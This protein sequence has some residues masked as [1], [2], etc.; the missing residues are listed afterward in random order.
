MIN[1]TITNTNTDNFSPEIREC[2]KNV[3][4][5]YY[6]VGTP[7]LHEYKP[8]CERLLSYA[9]EEQSDFL[10]A[11]GYFCLMNYYGYD[12][13]PSETVRCALDG[14]KYQQKAHESTFVARS[15]N[16]LGLFTAAMG[17]YMKAVDYLLYSIDISTQ[18][19]LDY[20]RGMAEVNLAD[21]F[22]RTSNYE[23]ALYHYS[24]AIKY[25]LK[26][27]ETLSVQTYRLLSSALCNQGY[28][29]LNTGKLDDAVNNVK[30]INTYIEQM[31]EHNIPFE[32]FVIYTY[33][34]SVYECQGN[35]DAARECLAESDAALNELS[36][37]TTFADDILAYIR[38]N[39]C[40]RS[41][42]EYINIL[43]NFISRA[44]VS[45]APFHLSRVLL[46]ERI[47]IAIT[48]KE[49]DVFTT[50]SMRLFNLYKEQNIQQNE[51]T[52]RAEQMHHENQIIHKQ[53]YELVHRNKALMSQ[54]Q[55]DALTGLPNRAYLNDY[56]ETTLSKALKNGCTFG[57]EILDIDYFKNINDNYGHIEGDRYLGAVS[58]ALN[59]ITDEHSDIFAARYGGDEFV[60]IYY[61]KTNEEIA[62]IMDEL[63]SAVNDIAL[64]DD[65][66]DGNSFITISQ[67]CLNRI[68]KPTNRI[69]DFLAHADVALYEIK[70]SG[71]NNYRLKDSFKR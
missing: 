16:V 2:I 58:A 8:Y 60:L 7:Q 32:H 22:H 4:E 49:Q 28:C 30:M 35:T 18:Y 46:E 63:K 71:K 51:N 66:P 19:Q 62:A 20:I 41:H 21:I 54:S 29:F 15:Y 25:S 56:A 59:K 70:R 48:D 50:Y 12:N 38:L 45:H 33:I 10:F 27:M 47:D 34:A 44:A 9:S 67:G 36:N 53:H 64:P 1:P 61:D 55:H 31:N 37:F 13:N 26:S 42:G 40:M 17:D 65:N 6:L 3:Q 68:P 69:W 43:D 14:I 39:K 23:R 52:L 57:I 5:K 24:E 11:L